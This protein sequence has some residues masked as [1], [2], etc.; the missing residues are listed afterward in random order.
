MI[1]KRSLQVALATP[2]GL[3]ALLLAEP[4]LACSVC[5]GGDPNSSMNQGVRAWML[6]LLPEGAPANILAF[7]PPLT[8]GKSHITKLIRA[9]GRALEEAYE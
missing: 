2:I 7:T 3:A 1:G 8:V 6:F 5:A 4:V 9:L